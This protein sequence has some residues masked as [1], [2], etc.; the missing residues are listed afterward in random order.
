MVQGKA[1]PGMHVLL[2]VLL[3][4]QRRQQRCRERWWTK[5]TLCPGPR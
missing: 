3:A 5:T 2:P 1:K 4:A